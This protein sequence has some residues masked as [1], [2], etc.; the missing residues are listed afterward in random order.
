MKPTLEIIRVLTI[1]PR[2]VAEEIDHITSDLRPYDWE[3][4]A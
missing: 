3:D 4:E 1:R 2:T